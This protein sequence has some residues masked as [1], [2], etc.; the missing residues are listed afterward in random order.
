MAKDKFILINVEQGPMQ[1]ESSQTILKN[2]VENCTKSTLLFSQYY[3]ATSTNFLFIKL[4][5]V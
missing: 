5:T 4:F 2:E 3:H 1:L